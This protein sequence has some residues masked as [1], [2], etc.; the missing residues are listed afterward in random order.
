MKEE[1]GK[2][3]TETE[4][5]LTFAQN[6]LLSSSL[7]LELENLKEIFESDT[8][9]KDKDK[10]VLEQ[11][12]EILSMPAEDWLEEFFKT[13]YEQ[14]P[15]DVVLGITLHLHSRFDICEGCAPDLAL[16]SIRLDGFVSQL[17]SF[18]KTR[19]GYVSREFSTTEPFFRLIT[20]CHDFLLDN[21]K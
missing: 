11:A 15:S 9:S 19:N 18:V 21:A 8:R 1:I 3:F 2:V 16:E 5:A 17:K 20:S 14:S 7:Y 6:P 10:E 4:K 12:Q 13:L